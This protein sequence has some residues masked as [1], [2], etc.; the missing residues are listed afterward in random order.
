MQMAAVIAA[1]LLGLLG[2]IL[3]GLKVGEMIRGRP[4][5][6]WLLN[7]VAVLVFMVLDFVGL[8]T[9][10]LW[11]ALGAVGLM[12]GTITGLKYGYNESIGVWRTIDGWTGADASMH[13]AA[14]DEDERGAGT[15]SSGN[16]A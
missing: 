10:H 6:Y 7:G 13:M 9:G 5:T 2:G 12:G 3:G 15:P 1:V 4:R 8:A 14:E 16:P 11:L